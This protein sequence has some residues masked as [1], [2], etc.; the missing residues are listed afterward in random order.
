MGIVFSLFMFSVLAGGLTFVVGR[1]MSEQLAVTSAMLL[2]MGGLLWVATG[3][4]WSGQMDILRDTALK[5]L[6]ML[7][8]VGVGATGLYAGSKLGHHRTPAP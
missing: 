8:C 1:L 7:F 3:L 4:E 2:L 5:A 6:A